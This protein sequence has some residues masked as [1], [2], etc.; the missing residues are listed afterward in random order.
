MGSVSRAV[1]PVT[2]GSVSGPGQVSEAAEVPGLGF[3][4]SSG[5]AG[6]W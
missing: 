1:Q 4:M 5:D 3:R 2:L 6:Q